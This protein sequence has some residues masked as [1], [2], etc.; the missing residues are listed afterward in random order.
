MSEGSG[1]EHKPSVLLL[2]RLLR[3]F[4][5]RP[6]SNLTL[7]LTLSQVLHEGTCAY[8]ESIWKLLV[9]DGARETVYNSLLPPLPPSLE[10]RGKDGCL[11]D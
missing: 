10:R 9:H 8:G 6:T 7:I 2:S 1:W 4:P 5:G 11:R 3:E